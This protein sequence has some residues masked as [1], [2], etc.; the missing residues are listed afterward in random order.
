MAALSPE[1]ARLLAV[2]ELRRRKLAG[3][4]FPEKVRAVVQLQRIVAPILRARGRQ[5]RVWNIEE[6]AARRP[7]GTP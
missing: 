3:L 5:V 1:M 2:K 4:P 6:S 7:P